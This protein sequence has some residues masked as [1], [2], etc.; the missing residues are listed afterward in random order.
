MIMSYTELFCIIFMCHFQGVLL[1]CNQPR[2]R[3]WLSGNRVFSY[4]SH[5]VRQA[6]L[7]F[8]AQIPPR[9]PPKIVCQFALYIEEG[10]LANFQRA[11]TAASG[12]P[13]VCNLYT[14]KWI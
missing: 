11:P 3:G 2:I 5:N 1:P 13:K 10:K 9:M 7:V 6:I 4:T 14:P 8:A 12:G